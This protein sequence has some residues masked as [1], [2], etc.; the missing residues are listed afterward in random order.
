MAIRGSAQ[1]ACLE[2]H[3]QT[4]DVAAAAGWQRSVVPHVEMLA[5]RARD[6]EN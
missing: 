4:E 1:G 3:A 2:N 6:K 5:L